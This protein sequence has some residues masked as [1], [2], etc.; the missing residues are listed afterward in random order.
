VKS[1]KELEGTVAR[2]CGTVRRQSLHCEQSPPPANAQTKRFTPTTNEKKTSQGNKKEGRQSNNPNRNST[3]KRAI[4]LFSLTII[5]FSTEYYEIF[6][7]RKPTN[8]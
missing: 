8:Y 7:S 2:T 4:S 1:L 5:L 6:I 3:E